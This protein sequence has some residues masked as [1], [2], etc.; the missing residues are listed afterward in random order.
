MSMFNNLMK[1]VKSHHLLVLLGL[2]VLGVVLMHYSG[3][4]SMLLS[5]MDNKKDKEPTESVVSSSPTAAAPE[6][7]N[8]GPAAV[9]GSSMSS[10]S[11]SSC[12]QKPV[13]DPKDLLPNDS[14][15]DWASLNPSSDLKN[16]NLLNAGHHVGINTVGSSLRNANLQVRSEPANPRMDVSPWM[17][18]T[19]EPDLMRQPFEIG[20]SSL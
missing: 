17:N 11:H 15:N 12:S 14:N 5:G 1:S 2:L 9:S 8:S 19:I 16:V 20:S 7:H 6:G 18:T 3:K 10:V 13:V 4:K